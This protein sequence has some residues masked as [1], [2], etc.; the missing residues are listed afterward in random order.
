MTP[1]HA[2][3]YLDSLQQ[4]TMETLKLYNY[5]YSFYH[6]LVTRKEAR[7][8]KDPSQWMKYLASIQNTAICN[9]ISNSSKLLIDL[10]DCMAR[11]VRIESGH[12]LAE[13]INK[14]CHLPMLK[15]EDKV[16]EVMIEEIGDPEQGLAIALAVVK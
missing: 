12:K 1:A 14:T 6:H 15:E 9:C 16:N 4:K 3:A 5:R 10:E 11:A 2:C 7:E 8:N 13:G